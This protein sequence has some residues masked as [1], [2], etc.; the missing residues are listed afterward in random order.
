MENLFSERILRIC[1]DIMD[2]FNDLTVWQ[3]QSH[4]NVLFI[5]AIAQHVRYYSTSGLLLPQFQATLLAKL[6]AT[7]LAKLLAALL[8]KLQAALL[9]YLLAEF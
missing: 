7:L 2:K 3:T 9:A 8:A 6:Q 4:L 1:P 5:A